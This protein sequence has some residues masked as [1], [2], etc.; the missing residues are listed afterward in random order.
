M[1]TP[2][3]VRGWQG[4]WLEEPWLQ[5][6]VTTLPV[7]VHLTTQTGESMWSLPPPGLGQDFTQ[8]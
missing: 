7:L 6:I 2:P 1:P 4:P 5:Y 3:E 8:D